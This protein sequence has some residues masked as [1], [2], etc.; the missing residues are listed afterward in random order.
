M[1][2]KH[3]L[4][5][6]AVC[7]AGMILPSGFTTGG[8]EP[9]TKAQLGEMLFFDPVLSKDRTVSCASCH[10]PQ[11]AF[12]DTAVF[13]KGING[14][15][16]SRNTPA[17]TNQSARPN[18]FWDG[19]AGT[20]EEQ[21]LQ[22]IISPDEMG[23]PAQEAV[24]RLNAD[25]RYLKAFKQLFNSE[26]T[27][28]NMLQAIAA[29]ERTLETANSPYDRYINGDDNAMSP[30]AIRGRLLFIG[31]ANCSN[32][33]SGEDF[34]ADRFKNIGLF[35]GR[36]LKDAGRFNITRDSA[37]MGFFKVPSLRNVAVTAP[38]MHNGMFKTLRE[39]IAYYNKPDSF[40]TDG[41]KRDLSLNRP[42]DLTEQ[43]VSDME[44]FLQALTDDRFTKR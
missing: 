42:L 1:V 8:P 5:I 41:V 35:N 40:V 2:W 25:E 37:H 12:A 22:P 44:A 11:F 19:R 7:I 14:K 6:I 32:C 20:L 18:Y 31:K 17:I 21:A 30:A 33:H 26:A 24:A 13:S 10:L 27:E 16:T 28:K 23:L 4:W 3:K 29:F 15:L 9:A 39:V 38:Y 36:Q 34:T 43:E